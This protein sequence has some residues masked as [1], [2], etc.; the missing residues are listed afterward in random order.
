MD[1][2]KRRFFFLICSPLLC[3]SPDNRFN[4]GESSEAFLCV[5]EAGLFFRLRLPRPIAPFSTSREGGFADLCSSFWTCSD[6]SLLFAG[7]YRS[8]SNWTISRQLGSECFL[9]DVLQT[10]RWPLVV[11][12]TA[13]PLSALFLSP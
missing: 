11:T 9:G 1:V 4:V 5:D 7:D 13:P 8:A 6:F 12:E 2:L 3:S 10:P